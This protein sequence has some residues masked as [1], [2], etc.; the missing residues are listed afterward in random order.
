MHTVHMEPDLLLVLA[1]HCHLQYD[2]HGQLDV[3]QVIDCQHTEDA[4]SVMPDLQLGM[5]FVTF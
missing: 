1:S 2:G 5:L 4:H 3:P